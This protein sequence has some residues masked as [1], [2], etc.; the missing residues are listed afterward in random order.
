MCCSLTLS[1]SLMASAKGGH[2]IIPCPLGPGMDYLCI[3]LLRG[4]DLPSVLRLAV[5]GGISIP[6]PSC[7]SLRMAGTSVLSRKVCLG[8]SH[9]FSALA[10]LC[11][12]FCAFILFRDSPKSWLFLVRHL[13]FSWQELR[14]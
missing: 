13:S 14:V 7:H 2:P 5:L 3:D 4:R 12:S 9:P 11:V 10:L 8:G 1:G 6:A